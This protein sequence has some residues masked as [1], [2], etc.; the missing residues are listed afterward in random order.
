M[1]VVSKQGSGL[2][3]RGP[4][5]GASRQPV[6]LGP[7]LPGP[8]PVVAPTI[9]LAGGVIVRAVPNFSFSVLFTD[10]TGADTGGLENAVLGTLLITL[11]VLVI[12][13]VVSILTGLYLTEF[14]HGRHR[15]I[16]RGGYE[17]LAGIPSIVLGTSGTSPWWWAWAG[18]SACCGPSWWSRW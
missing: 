1:A 18:I 7:V 14:A 16:L 8:G 17:V 10:T 15:S 9:W 5:A 13:G 12:G 6:V 3:G 4:G 11:G 2:D